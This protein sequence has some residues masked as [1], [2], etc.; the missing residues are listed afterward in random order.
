MTKESMASDSGSHEKVLIDSW[1]WGQLTVAAFGLTLCFSS[2]RPFAELIGG[3]AAAS[4]DA[5]IGLA[6]ISAIA[7]SVITI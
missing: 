6:F 5:L 4:L 2:A 7:I 3:S 1:P